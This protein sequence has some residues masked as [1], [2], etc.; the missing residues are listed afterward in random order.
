MAKKHLQKGR[1]KKNNSEYEEEVLQVDRVTRVV[2]GGRRLRFRTTVIVGNKKGKVGIGLGKA[3][4]V[5][6]AIQK[7]ITKAKKE[8]INVPI[9]KDTETIP[10]EI[11]I[12]YKAAKILILPASKGTGIIAGGS[13]RKIL[14]LAG[15]KN[16]LSKSL[17][18]TNR[19]VTAQATIVA[20]KAL[21]EVRG[22]KGLND[23]AAP[24]PKDK[25]KNENKVE[26]GNKAE[27]ENKAEV[28]NK[29]ENETVDTSKK[30]TT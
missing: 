29:A 17:G 20:L 23:Q 2:K 30:E 7:A 9:V 18:T 8:V 26:V 4:E 5:A 15:I 1:K 24:A 12:K 25:A 28:G 10:H 21:K 27:N 13:V 22:G 16:C 14:E 6:T 11:K 3:T 19:V